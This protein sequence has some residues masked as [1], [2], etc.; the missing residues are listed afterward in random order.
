MVDL[1]TKTLT[2]WR[3]LY[4]R[5]SVVSP[6]SLQFYHHSFFS[7][8]KFVGLFERMRLRM[9]RYSHA[10]RSIM[11]RTFRIRK[12]RLQRIRRCRMSRSRMRRNIVTV[13]IRQITRRFL[14]SSRKSYKTN[15]DWKC[16]IVRNRFS[17]RNGQ[18]VY[19]M[20][21]IR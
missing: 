11:S 8:I 5:S 15:I 12:N 20:I 1:N 18:M 2:S 10:K 6:K 14:E 7:T 4:Q 16:I 13:V 17:R 21:L 19:Y 9:S 3:K